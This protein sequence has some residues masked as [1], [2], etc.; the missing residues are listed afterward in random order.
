MP[1]GHV[2]HRLADAFTTTF[3]SRRV[4]VTS[5]QGR[6]ETATLDGAVLVRGDAVGKHLF[7]DFADGQ[8][9]HIHLGLIG[10]LRFAPL[11]PPRGQVRLR[12]H[13]EKTAADLHGPQWCRAITA[14][15]RD[16]VVEASGPDP[17]R[18]DA[19]PARGFARVSRSKRSIA[20]L[21]MDQ[22]VAAGVG[23]IFRAEVLFRHRLDPTTPGTAIRR[24]TWDTL[25]QD[26]AELMGVAVRRGRID[27]VRGAHTPQAQQ[28]PP[29]EDPHGGEVYV[30]RRAGQPCLVCA[31]AVRTALLD[32]RN[33]Y[34][35]PR[36]QRLK[37]VA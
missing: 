32:G 14:R 7:L 26:L 33:L 20:A 9:I 4:S 19:D 3:G 28:R 2:I 15:E 12:I 13:D 22:R 11:A 24:R 31:T 30:Y 35:C 29:R 17:L 27:T 18:L 36:C 8:V 25:W 21:L 1:E 34:W 10:T 6:F 37:N 5:P 23:N 16:A